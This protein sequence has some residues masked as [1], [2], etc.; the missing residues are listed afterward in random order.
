MDETFISENYP[1]TFSFINIE[2]LIEM[3]KCVNKKG[4][5]I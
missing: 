5:H 1:T 3:R 4:V 2:L